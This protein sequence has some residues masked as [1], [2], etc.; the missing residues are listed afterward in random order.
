[1]K[2]RRRPRSRR[3]VEAISRSWSPGLKRGASAASICL[4]RRSDGS[5]IVAARRRSGAYPSLLPLRLQRQSAGASLHRSRH[6]AAA[7]E[8]C[9]I[10]LRGI[11]LEIREPHAALLPAAQQP[12]ERWKIR[13]A[14]ELGVQREHMIARERAGGHGEQMVDGLYAAQ[15]RAADELI[16]RRQGRWQLRD[17]RRALI[18]RRP[19][20]P[21]AAGVGGITEAELALESR[22]VVIDLPAGCAVHDGRAVE[23]LRE[24]IAGER[25]LAPGPPLARPAHPVLPAHVIEAVHAHLEAAARDILKLCAAPAADVRP[26]KQH[27]VEQRLQTVVPHHGSALDLAEEAAAEDTPDG[28]PGVVGAQAEEKGRRHAEPPGAIREPRRTLAC[29]PISVDVDLEGDQCHGRRP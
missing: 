17:R 6:D 19:K 22:H 1:M 7:G 9:D 26:G 15:V 8:P 5:D 24:L 11:T 14:L 21:G 16:E 23:D 3:T 25:E 29:A 4:E 18:A 10:E 2:A 12:L 13:A 28:A 27:A 20:W